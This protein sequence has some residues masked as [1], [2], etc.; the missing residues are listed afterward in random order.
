[1]GSFV[2]TTSQNSRKLGGVTPTSFGLSVIAANDAS[3]LGALPLAGGTMTGDLKFTDDTYDIGK[4]GE[5]R[6]RDGYFSRIV[7][8]PLCTVQGP[9]STS[10]SAVLNVANL[11]NGDFTNIGEFLAPNT[12][13]TKRVGI[14]IGVASS[15]KNLC[16]IGMQYVASGSDSNAFQVYFHSVAEPAL[17][18][19]AGSNTTLQ[20]GG[21]TSSYPAIRRNTNYIQMVLADNS[22]FADVYLRAL[23]VSEAEETRTNL[24]LGTASVATLSTDG[25]MAANSDIIVPSQSAVTAYVASQVT[26]LMEIKGSTNCSANPNY[27]AGSK[28]DAYI[29]TVAGKIGGASGKTVEAS[30]WYICLADNAGGTEASVG[31]SWA[32]VEHNIIGAL[33]SSNNLSDLAN[34]A[35]ARTNLGCGTMATQDANNVNISGGLVSATGGT[36]DGMTITGIANPATV[37]SD[38]GLGTMALQASTAYVAIAGATMTDLLTAPT[39]T[40]S[41]AAAP[42]QTAPLQVV[43]GNNA[44]FTSIVRCMAPNTTGTKNVS[45]DI[46]VLNSA[47]NLISL[48]FQYVASGSDSNAFAIF[49]HSDAT[50]V[51]KVTRAGVVTLAAALTVANG[52]TGATTLTGIVKGNGTSAFSEATEGSDYWKPGGTDVAVADGGTGSSTAATARVALSINELL[53]TIT[54]QGANSGTG[55]TDLATYSVAGGKLAATGDSVWFEASG[56]FAANANNKTVRVRFGSGA[57]TQVF[58]TGISTA[59][60]LQWTIRGR[61]IR[62]GAATQKGYA[63]FINSG[64]GASGSLGQ[65]TTALNHTLSGAADLRV[66]GQSGTG[67]NDILLET[68]V[69]GF[70][71]AAP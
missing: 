43:N 2:P 61:I 8:T 20:L 25:T 55:E 27:P 22:D 26:G 50:P 31:T 56:T 4:T 28:G 17:S 5:F 42:S 32:A 39:I 44:D 29:V 9:L 34:A 18:V 21:R 59:N 52:G 13:G 71:Y 33:V 30:D 12:T 51:F 49:F 68:F 40:V 57:T 23:H 3:G 58:S 16:T 6:P 70:D 45:I 37:R 15:A 54:T 63:Q 48:A 7:V 64:G 14:N 24:G 65:S 1:M 11:N 36:L 60:N 41:G 62:T 53:K 67:S 38:L 19:T 69:V 46:G 35:T 47:K 10:V 66:T